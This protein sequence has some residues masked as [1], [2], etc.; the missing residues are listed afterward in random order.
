MM[1]KVKVQPNEVT[2][3]QCGE[4]FP[5]LWSGC[6]RC[7]SEDTPNQRGRRPGEYVR[8]PTVPTISYLEEGEYERL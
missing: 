4:V 1:N 2:C 5:A 6:P 3:L 7:S 8:T